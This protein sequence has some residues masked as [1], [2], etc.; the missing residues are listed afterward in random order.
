MKKFKSKQTKSYDFL[1]KSAEEYQNVIF[2]VCRKIIMEEDFP[3]MFSK[4][5]LYMIWKLKGPQE[6][7]KNNRFIHMK[8]HYLPRTVESIVVNER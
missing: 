6:I 5:I 3:V 8:E 7:L 4:T 2:K 1:L